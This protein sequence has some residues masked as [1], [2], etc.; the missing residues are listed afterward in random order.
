MNS[1]HPR[2]FN[3][4]LS[5]YILEKYINP[6]GNGANTP[7]A[8]YMY[9]IY[10][11]WTQNLTLPFGR[12]PSLAFSTFSNPNVSVPN[13]EAVVTVDAIAPSLNCQQLNASM[14]RR[15]NN[16]LTLRFDLQGGP[17]GSWDQFTIVTNDLTESTDGFRQTLSTIKFYTCG[18]SNS[19]VQTPAKYS[20][21]SRSGLKDDGFILAVVNFIHQKVNNTIIQTASSSDPNATFILQKSNFLACQGS[22]TMQKVNVTAEFEQN[23]STPVVRAVSKPFGGKDAASIKTD[24]IPAFW[25]LKSP[26]VHMIGDFVKLMALRGSGKPME[27]LLDIEEMKQ[28]ASAAFTAG[29]SGV[30]HEIFL[31]NNTHM[32]QGHVTMTVNRLF[33]N[34]III[35]PMMAIFATLAV[36]SLLLL[37]LRK[38]DFITAEPWSLG[39]ILM[40]LARFPYLRKLGRQVD[41]SSIDKFVASSVSQLP[42]LASPKRLKTFSIINFKRLNGNKYGEWWLPVPLKEWALCSNLLLLILLIIGLEVIQRISD[43]NNGFA[44]AGSQDAAQL[45]MRFVPALVMVGVS[46]VVN[47]LDVS[48]TLFAPLSILRRGNVTSLVLSKNPFSKLIPH[49]VYWSLKFKALGPIFSEIAA[50][51]AAFLAIAASGLYSFKT[52]SQDSPLSL[53]RT[54]TFDLNLR[55]TEFSEGLPSESGN[56]AGIILSLLEHQNLSY[57]GQTFQ[58][59]VMPQLASVGDTHDNSTPS[60]GLLKVN[61]PVF[62]PNLDCFILPTEWL[63]MNCSEGTVRFTLPQRRAGDGTGER[64]RNYEKNATDNK[65]IS[66]K[67]NNVGGVVSWIPDGNDCCSFAFY[68]GSTT[69]SNGVEPPEFNATAELENF[70]IVQCGQQVQELS[71]EVVFKDWRSGVVD[72]LQPPKVDESSVRL[73][74]NKRSQYD[75]GFETYF[76]WAHLITR[77]KDTLQPFEYDQKNSSYDVFL[78]GIL[79]GNDKV[80]L[81]ELLGKQNQ[82]KFTDAFRRVYSKMIAQAINSGGRLRCD[83][84]MQVAECKQTFSGTS[85]FTLTKIQQDKTSKEFLQSL[86][87]L[88]LA[89]SIIAI[90]ATRRDVVPH[91]HC[92][93][94]GSIS[95]LVDSRL[96]DEISATALAKSCDILSARGL[97]ESLG[98]IGG[99]CSLGFWERE[100]T[101]RVVFGVDI[102]RPMDI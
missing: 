98:K 42:N 59:L 96:Y 11:N 8:D 85:S 63:T 69:C 89:M 74:R 80:P 6:Y 75:P 28:A 49:C 82:K 68:I 72:T 47:S 92:T 27:S 32:V 51:A 101:N 21:Y 41:A 61:I 30:L 70:T 34:E 102:D 64:L 71:A 14:P 2:L 76:K 57:P 87:G 81:T 1:F 43:A 24:V 7:P 78:Q 55:Y 29:L 53:A 97:Q 25:L 4:S 5:P 60:Q 37:P 38:P 22:Y 16:T 44:P 77:T 84:S 17:C 31:T 12:T 86:L 18:K 73:V 19:T 39:S 99:L 88:I 52:V 90:L 3:D 23:K 66:I 45:L 65:A 67:Q 13:L 83:D 26:L 100:N 40:I 48:I 93:L 33:I 46:L 91:N 36:L 10:A 50:F 79:F 95:L 35:W 54:D 56:D 9:S 62:R 20:D 15:L 58:T 94:A